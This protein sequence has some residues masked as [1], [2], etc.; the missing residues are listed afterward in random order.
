[1]LG[2]DSVFWPRICIVQDE[3][4]RR[5]AEDHDYQHGDGRKVDPLRPP[6]CAVG[7][8]TEDEMEK[9]APHS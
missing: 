9:G 3:K 7:R 4:E 5:N 8:R 2:A 6:R 1:M